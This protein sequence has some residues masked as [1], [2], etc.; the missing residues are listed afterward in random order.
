MRLHLLTRA[1]L[2]LCLAASA[3]PATGCGAG[4]AEDGD[5]IELTRVA[6]G[7]DG[8][9]HLSAP[10]GDP[11]LF[12]VE[13]PGRIRIIADGR[14]LERPFLDIA[15]RVRS[16]G[17]RGLL[18]V[19][20]HPRYAENGRFFVNYTDRDGD[21]RIAEFRVSADPDRADP[22]SERLLLAV[23]QPYA[24]HNGGHVL[25]GPDGR[26]Y[27]GMGDG[28]AANDPHGHGRNPNTL[29]GAILRIDVDAG[30]PYAI[31]PDNPWAKGGGRPEIWAI[32]ARNPWRMWF[33]AP[34]SLLYVADVGQNRW[35]E[36]HV[37]PAAAAGLDY[38]WNVM[39]GRHCFRGAGCDTAGLHL[40]V[41]E[42][43]HDEGCSITGGIVYRGRAVPGLEGHYLYADYC[44][45]WIRSFRY[46]G[47]RAVDRRKLARDVGSIASFGE[48]AD[49]EAY[50]VTLE[51]A[52]Y[53]ID[54]PR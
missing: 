31:P 52:V 40:P 14:L 37:A 15:A 23:E 7:L 29:L 6:D 1:A 51:G 30:E 19:A 11:R 9:L 42:Y 16:G 45:G 13:Q 46:A 28:G 3:L 36:V 43:G 47:G 8:P 32:G 20:F 54:A 34:E 41:L 25:F 50:V 33:D 48:G 35:E 53:R 17:E 22:D 49:R 10:A 2:A 44:R 5:A 26:L 39:E 4:A 21:T 24:N 27:A 12:V 18:S 38:G